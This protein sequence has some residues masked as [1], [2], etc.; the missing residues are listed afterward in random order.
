M[1]EAAAAWL[2][3]VVSLGGGYSGGGIATARFIDKPSCEAAAIDL[4]NLD[5]RVKARCYRDRKP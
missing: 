5:S 2:L 3:V 4:E 1:M